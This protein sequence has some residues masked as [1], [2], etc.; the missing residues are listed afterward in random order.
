MNSYE[1]FT[2]SAIRHN[3]QARAIS[4]Q[5]LS[6]KTGISMPRLRRCMAFWSPQ[7]LTLNDL[8]KIYEA[9][10]ITPDVQ[11]HPELA[12]LSDDTKSKICAL[13]RSVRIE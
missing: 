1:L 8:G 2:I 3:M 5:T 9:L 10:D 13:I 6:D 12:M 4:F 11:N 7:S